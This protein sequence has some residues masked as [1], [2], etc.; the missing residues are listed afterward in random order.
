MT[1]GTVHAYAKLGCRCEIC[2]TYMKCVWA[3]QLSDVEKEL[4]ALLHE[5]APMGLTEDCPA[6]RRAA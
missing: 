2:A 1:H 4:A 3:Q 6:R 5:L